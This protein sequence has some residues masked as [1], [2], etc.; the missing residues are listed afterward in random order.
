M[1]RLTVSHWYLINNFNANIY[2]ETILNSHRS[3]F[4]QM[5]LLVVQSLTS[6]KSQLKC[7]ILRES[8]FNC[9]KITPHSS[10]C[11]LL[12]LFISLQHF[13]ISDT[14]LYTYT[15]KFICMYRHLYVYCHLPTRAKE[16]TSKL[17][18]PGSVPRILQAL[19]QHLI[20]QLP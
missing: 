18:D 9:S 16:F 20:N 17:Q 7:R 4:H 3:Y 19:N 10:L 1:T 14:I 5:F 12:L 8:F 13:S 15:H 11:P 2:L 6:F